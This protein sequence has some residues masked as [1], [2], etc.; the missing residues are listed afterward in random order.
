MRNHGVD[1]TRGLIFVNPASDVFKK[2]EQSA[3]CQ[4]VK[5]Y[6]EDVKVEIG[7][8]KCRCLLDDANLL[9]S[10]SYYRLISESPRLQVVLS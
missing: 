10:P 1:I 3:G 8:N 6:V 2:I 7:D 4:D 9:A 5:Y